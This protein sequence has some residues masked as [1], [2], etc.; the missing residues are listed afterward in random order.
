MRENY[1]SIRLEDLAFDAMRADG[2]N[3]LKSLIKNI[4]VRFCR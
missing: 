4:L 2:N 3:A 1:Q